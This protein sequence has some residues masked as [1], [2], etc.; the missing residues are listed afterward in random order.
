MKFIDICVELKLLNDEDAETLRAA[1]TRDE[2]FASQESLKRGL[3]TASDVDIVHCLRHPAD[4]VPGYEI[5]GLVGRGGMGVVYRAKQLDLDRIVALKTVLISNVSSPNA[6]ARFER[7]AKTLARLQHP[8]IVQ[9]LNFGQHQGRYYFAMEYVMG[10][11]CEQA[12]QQQGRLA[13]V[14]VWSMVRQVASGLMHALRQNV[15]HRDIKP[16]NLLLLPAPEGSSK[17]VTKEVVKITDFGLAMFADTGPDHLRLTTADKI[18]GSP[19]YMSPEQFG[20]DSVDFRADVYSLGATAWHLIFGAPPFQGKNLPSL[21]SQKTLPVQADRLSM[22]VQLPQDQWDLLLGM[23]DPNE[24]NRPHTYESLIAA[25]DELKLDLTEDVAPT[26]NSGEMNLVSQQP[27]MEAVRP[28]FP[29][30]ASGSKS[31]SRSLSQTLEFEQPENEPGHANRRKVI[32]VLAAFLVIAAGSIG[33]FVSQNQKIE[34]GPRLYTQP[35]DGDNLFD[36]ETLSGWDVGG[37]MVGAWNTVVAPD[38]ATAIACTTPQGAITRRLND[39]E[40]PRITLLVLPRDGFDKVDID[41]AFDSKESDDVR[42]SVRFTPDSVLLGQKTEDFGLVNEI[43]RL[44]S[45]DKM[46][47]RFHVVYLERQATDW[48]VFLEERLLGTIPI[49][50]I[51][52]GSAIRLVVHPSD[53]WT[54][55]TPVAFFTDVRVEYLVETQS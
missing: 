54:P 10:R 36:G 6:A 55:Q 41:F 32:V 51:G 43:S 26:S 33:W 31:D 19:A 22:P 14:A 30:P 23:L 17:S 47:E 11:S 8:N 53:G 28:N 45:P 20:G 38:S 39:R 15:I 3:L 4:V 2:A 27:T 1:V 7:E 29:T 9:A 12:L 44:D 24:E 46:F 21:L 42:G 16:A 13:P 35:T 34:R 48:Y 50:A 37:S 5:I 49:D 52:D 25:V 18:M 40:N